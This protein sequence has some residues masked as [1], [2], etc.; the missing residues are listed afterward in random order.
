MD[1][2]QNF[3]IIDSNNL[4]NIKSKLYGFSVQRE[5]IYDRNNLKNFK[6]DSM[7]GQGC[8]VYINV[9]NNL[10]TITQDF[11][12]CYGIYLY[13]GKDYFAISNSFLM[14]LEHI[15][16]YYELTL[17]IHYINHFLISG[18]ESKSCFETPVNEIE[19]IDRN[20]IIKIDIKDKLIYT[21]IIN[22]SLCTVDINSLE[23][24]NYLDNWYYFWTDLIYSLYHR[25]NNIIVDLSGGYDSRMVFLL[26]LCSNID[27]NKIRCR[28]F[29]D[30]KHC[31]SEDYDIASTIARDYNLELNNNAFNNYHYL[32]IEDS[33]NIELYS[34]MCFH[35]EPY[36][37]NKKYYN[38]IFHFSGGGGE[39]IRSNRWDKSTNDFIKM[40]LTQYKSAFSYALLK[41]LF[42]SE[43]KII[44]CSFNY[45][46][47]KYNITNTT[48]STLL[49][50]TQCRFHFGKLQLVNMF[51]NIFTINPLMDF[52]L[53]KIKRNKLD[54]NDYNL[55][56]A[57]IYTRYCRKLLNYKFEGNRYYI[58]SET[59]NNAE[60]INKNFPFLNRHTNK[61]QNF[62]VPMNY[63]EQIA[64]NT[65]NNHTS[66][67]FKI[68]ECHDQIK[69]AFDSDEVRGLFSTMF[70]MQIYDFANKYF[71]SNS[72]FCIRHCYSI[73][74][75]AAIIKHIKYR[76]KESPK[77]L[78]Q[79]RNVTTY[80]YGKNINFNFL[81]YITARV[82]IKLVSDSSSPYISINDITDN[83][84]KAY[85]PDYYTGNITGYTILSYLG[86]M[87]ASLK[88][89]NKGRITIALRTVD[90][91]DNDN[92]ILQFLIS[93]TR[94]VINEKLIFDSKR[95]ICHNKPFV[96]NFD[97]NKDQNFTIE[98]SWMPYNIQ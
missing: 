33:F 36:F 43:K 86:K 54:S 13:K 37:I 94:L 29:N 67:I 52:N 69:Y 68:S 49:Y 48:C 63:N 64:L 42:V 84:A 32:S 1:Y 47:E 20:A 87:K 79:I 30:S 55:L 83:N 45:I 2:R 28:S 57:V 76:S 62:K 18:L 34:K 40:S 5:G 7:N 66:R 91:R 46:K 74:S 78:F 80:N 51:S 50:D 14:L 90:V 39:A 88:S 6:L 12:G 61:N 59:I 27:I 56:M 35:K 95:D 16:D 81:P 11:N 96:Y 70:D 31:H 4:N 92:K 22:H 71:S 3:F 82:D 98:I 44:E 75:I 65:E 15:S 60:L 38:R 17:N 93:Y 77:K 41:R 24:I 23:G 53:W 89:H 9:E 25:T 85:T 26:F 21:E 19:V 72:F 8:Y 73:L 58:S 10:I 97:I